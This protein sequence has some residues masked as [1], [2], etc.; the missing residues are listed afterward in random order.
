[1]QY[2]L[3]IRTK[4]FETVSWDEFA[5]LLRGLGPETPL[6]KVVSIRAEKDRKVIKSFSKEQKRIYN[7]WRKRKTE[8]IDTKTYEKQMKEL[9]KEIM[10]FLK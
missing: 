7:E 5:A 1:M 8:K 2:G 9:E 10:Y 6:G 4:E 3:R